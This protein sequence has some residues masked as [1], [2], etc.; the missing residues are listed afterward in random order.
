MNL[1]ELR[2]KNPAYNET[3]VRRLAIAMTLMYLWILIW[4]LVLKLGNE[5]LLVNN[6]TNLK[7]LT[8]MERILW[9]IVPFNY[10]GEGAYTAQLIKDTILNTLVFVPF[11]V[12]LS[13]IFEKTNLLRDVAICL[14]IPLT[15]ESIQFLT[16]LGNPATEDLI[17]NVIGCFLG[18]AV[19]RLILARISLLNTV[20]LLAAANAVLIVSVAASLIT[21]A[22][23]L[24]VIIKIITR[25]L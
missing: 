20:R 18:F 12:T 25:T 14:G 15:I 3:T 16:M 10:R 22:G 17:T 24:D 9:D 21:T 11:G 1:K 7:E 13:Y 2:E 23:A 5:T 4:A 6:Y 8:P 19:Y